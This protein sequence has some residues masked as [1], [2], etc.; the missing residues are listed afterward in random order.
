MSAAKDKRGL[1][2][3]KKSNPERWHGAF[4]STINTVSAKLCTEFAHLLIHEGKLP[5]LKDTLARLISQHTATS[6]LL[7][8]LAQARSDSLADILGP[9]VFRA[10]RTAMEHQQCNDK[11]SNNMRSRILRGEE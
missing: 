1:E 10:L 2:A 8:W 11:T 7:L 5:Q 9:E 6:D 3:F 4:I